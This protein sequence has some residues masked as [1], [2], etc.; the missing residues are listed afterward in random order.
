MHLCKQLQ[1]NL[2]LAGI[3]GVQPDEVIERTHKAVEDKLL[4]RCLTCDALMEYH[5]SMEQFEKEGSLYNLA[6]NTHKKLDPTKLYS[7]PA[8]GKIL[9]V[10]KRNNGKKKKKMQ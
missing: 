1:Q 10:I 3:I 7:F 2:Y 5:L 8:L 4:Y 9:Q 6:V